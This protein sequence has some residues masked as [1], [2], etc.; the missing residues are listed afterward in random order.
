VTLSYAT[1][2]A[3]FAGLVTERK[4]DPGSLATPGTPL[5]TLERE[6]N[7]RL[8]VSMDE[9][10]LGLAR[11]NENVAVELDASNQTVVGRVAE[12][13]PSVDAATRSFNVK[14][15]L[16]SVP[17]LRAGM[18]GRA[19]FTAA[20]R[21]TLLVPGSAVIDRGQIR[22]VYVVHGDIARLRFLTLSEAR[23]KQ[24]EV[25]SGLTAGER[26]ILAPPP[27]LADGSRVRIQEAAK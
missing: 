11:I 9:S 5:L 2:A 10:R 3:P 20:K 23:D 17:S 19:A 16:P 6:G 21:R 4:A 15:D 26:I 13:M 18:F 25:L 24:H 22:S 7:L 1:L 12:I 14:I 8:E 27:F